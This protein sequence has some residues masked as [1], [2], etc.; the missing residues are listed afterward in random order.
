[1]PFDTTPVE[2]TAALFGGPIA[3]KAANPIWNDQGYHSVVSRV[4][5]AP[6]EEPNGAFRHLLNST[7][8][9]GGQATQNFTTVCNTSEVPPPTIHPCCTQNTF[10]GNDDGSIAIVLPFN[11]SFF[12]PPTVNYVRL[13][14][15]SPRILSNVLRSI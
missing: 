6:L 13:S 9:D 11:I 8:S 4:G 12:G 1:V 2:K 14:G 15:A 3:P 5:G 10:A 7:S